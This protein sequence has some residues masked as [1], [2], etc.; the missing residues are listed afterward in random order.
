MR[1]KGGRCA[2]GKPV[3]VARKSATFGS[4]SSFKSFVWEKAHATS[5]GL[6]VKRLERC[7]VGASVLGGLGC[8]EPVGNQ[9]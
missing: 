7:Q 6:S 1:T 4:S 2:L 5:L 8:V 3:K 9:P